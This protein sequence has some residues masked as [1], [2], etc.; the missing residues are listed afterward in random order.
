MKVAYGTKCDFFPLFKTFLLGDWLLC[1]SC[2]IPFHRL[3]SQSSCKWFLLLDITGKNWKVNLPAF[4]VA[5][6]SNHSKRICLKRISF[7]P[8]CHLMCPTD[9][10]KVKSY[11]Q[12]SV[13]N[14]DNSPKFEN[15]RSSVIKRIIS[16]NRKRKYLFFCS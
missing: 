6:Y 9:R 15:L 12:V 13:F 7:R 4:S 3:I 14:P 11:S 10:Q 8:S 2:C 16:L 1:L 5:F